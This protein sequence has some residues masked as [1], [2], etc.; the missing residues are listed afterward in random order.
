VGFEAGMALGREAKRTVLVQIGQVR[1]FSNI[2]GRHIVQLDGSA[3]SRR[4]LATK[5][6]AAGCKANTDGVDWLTH[7][8]FGPTERPP[9][10]QRR[11]RKAW[12]FRKSRC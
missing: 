2:A 3:E 4:D 8:D 10:R 11:L 6:K 12:K 5:L 1:P 7:G 9:D